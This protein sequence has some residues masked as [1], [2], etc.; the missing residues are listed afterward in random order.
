MMSES[1]FDAYLS[2]LGKL[3]NLSARQRMQIAD[4]LRDHLE[5]RFQ[6]LLDQGTPRDEA[7]RLAVE[8][9]G[10]A[11]A[12]AQQF[13]LPHHIRRRRQL[14]RYSLGSA[15][16]IATTFVMA[17]FYWP[18]H[19]QEPGVQLQ[20]ESPPV[21]VLGS[22]GPSR[23]SAPGAAAH[24]DDML[25]KLEL[26]D[27]ELKFEDVPFLDAIESLSDLSDI[28]ILV[29][30]SVLNDRGIAPDTPVG[31]RLRHGAVTLRTA[32]ELCLENIGMG[33]GSMMIK[34]RD[35]IISVC[36][37]EAAYENR[38]YNCRDLLAGVTV[39]PPRQV[40]V[41]SADGFGQVPSGFPG[42]SALQ[43]GMEMPSAEGIGGGGMGVGGLGGGC[44]T[45]N[46]TSSAGPALI[47]VIQRATTPDAQWNDIDG[48]G[49]TISEY[50]GLIIVRNLPP[51]HLKIDELLT[52]IRTVRGENQPGPLS[53][54]AAGIPVLPGTSGP[55]A[56]GFEPYNPSVPGTPQTT[57]PLSPR[58][59]APGTSP[60]PLKPVGR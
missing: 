56:I 12:L 45:Y 42:D 1:E 3:L 2:L 10:D 22:P 44:P 37:P 40:A 53:G 49:G 51:V 38:V 23:S 35:G 19:R 50:D 16:V 32:I 34:P 20:A 43:P 24:Q 6:S 11:A 60:S 25:A 52:Q 39:S 29:D 13:T 9:L 5:E 27:F 48:A 18:A 17:A 58:P 28:D 57:S 4:E 8:D 14:M 59:G 36:N 54:A 41:T 33:R 46:A 55:A 26:R 47:N 21:G 15:V 7:L 30:E 31:L